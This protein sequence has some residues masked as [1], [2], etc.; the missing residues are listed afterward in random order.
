MRIEHAII[1]EV[2]HS[3]MSLND[4]K[5]LRVAL[6]GVHLKKGTQY[7]ILNL[8]IEKIDATIVHLESKNEHDLNSFENQTQ[9]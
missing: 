5:E 3:N 4:I 6:Y 8:I 9:E 7:R 2:E 1:S